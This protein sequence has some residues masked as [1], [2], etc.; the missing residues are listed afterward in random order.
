MTADEWVETAFKRNVMSRLG[1]VKTRSFEA[2]DFRM[3]N[4]SRHGWCPFGY[5]GK[6]NQNPGLY[7]PVYK[8]PITWPVAMRI[9]QLIS[10]NNIHEMSFSEFF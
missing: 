1:S 9:Y 10:S 3:H 4:L 6:A 2:Y 7:V 8:I 5:G